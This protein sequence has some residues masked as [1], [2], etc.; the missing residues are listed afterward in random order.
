MF[1]DF[2]EEY[3]KGEG[4]SLY[5][6]RAGPEGAP[7]IVL[8]HGYPQTS[9][10]WHGVAPILARSFQV[11][12]PDLRGY[13]KS[14][15]PTSDLSHSLYSKRV[16]AKDIVA[17]M[18][19]LGHKKYFIGAHDRGARVAHRLGLDHPH[20]VNAM[21][22]LDIA[23]TR[24][25]YA[26]TTTDFAR[27]Y[28]H[29]FFLIQPNPLPEQIISKDPEAFWKLKCFNQTSGD[30]PFTKEA[31]AEYLDAFNSPETIHSSC[32]DYRAA[33]S[34]DIEHDNE[35]QKKLVMPILALWAK[36]GVIEKCFDALKL[37]RQRADKVEGESINATHYMAEEIP[38]EIAKRMSE[39]FLRSIK[40]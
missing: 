26:D 21:V 25:M 4:A 9:A 29:W 2:K 38:E 14:D 24:E 16:M 13:G 11:I 12:C 15:K 40:S 7:P 28:W 8:L 23:P 37:W 34:I 6:R 1:K 36:R 32:E 39:F 19:H 22:L 35:D 31:L 27:A 18:K 20:Y 17:I 10:M 30:N 5:V 3:I 33:A